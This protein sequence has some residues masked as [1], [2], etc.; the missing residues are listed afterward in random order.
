MKKKKSRREAVDGVLVK[1]DHNEPTIGE[2]LASLNLIQNDKSKS[3]D[4]KIDDAKSSEKQLESS[5]QL[6]QPPT[7]DS[8]QVLLRQALRADDRALLLDCLYN[9]DEKVIAKS[10]ALLNLADVLKLL[11]SLVSIIQLRGAILACAL[12]WLKSVLLQH[13]SG[14]ISQ[15]SSLLALNSLFQLIESRVSA[16]ESAIQLSSCL[17]MLYTGVVDDEVDKNTSTVPVIY[18]DKDE[19]DEEIS[20]DAMETDDE[21]SKDEEASDDEFDGVS[22]TEGSD[23]MID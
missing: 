19:S 8:V 14:I 23:G 6:M 15:E 5:S 11:Q 16:F 22:D 4:S 18:E 1:E 7:A 12:P 10:I 17:D 20:E 3:D 9:R 2:K 13:A 21:D